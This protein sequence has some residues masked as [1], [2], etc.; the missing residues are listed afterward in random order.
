MQAARS[1]LPSRA[2]LS[3]MIRSLQIRNYALIESL[4]IRFSEGLT[5]ITGETGAGKSILLGALGMIMGERADTKALYNDAEKC[6]VE[7]VFDIS[8]YNLRPF[9]DANELDF[10]SELVI[11]REIL[12]S[13][14]SRAFVNDSPVNL[15][16]LEDLSDSLIDLHQQFDSLDINQVSFQLRMI[17]ALAGNKDL[18]EKYQ[19][20]F[21][22]YQS[23][24]RKLAALEA[25][26]SQ[27]AREIEFLQFQLDELEAANLAAGEQETLES[28][29]AK[30]NNAE[31]I[32]RVTGEAFQGLS[33]S[34]MAVLSQ[35]TDMRNALQS[36]EKVSPEIGQLNERLS[37]MIVELQDLSGEFEKIAEETEYDPGRIQEVEQRLD[38]IYRLQNKYGVQTTPELLALK[39]ETEQR[40]HTFADLSDQIVE[41]KEQIQAEKN[42]LQKL[43]AELRAKRQSVGPAF[44]E[45]VEKRLGQLSM[46]HAQLK[47]HF[48]ELQEF[49]ATGL[50]EVQFRF[51]ANKGG[52]LQ[53]IKDVASGGE[54]SRL[55]LAAKS[56]IAG[57]ISFPTLIFDEIDS[58]VSGDVALSVG[59]LLKALS[60]KHQVVS[61][62]HSPQI[63]AK[64]DA[65]YFIYK[66]DREDRTVTHVRLLNPDERI[67]AIATMLSQSPPSDSAIENARELMAG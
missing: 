13:G 49:T 5:I 28:E 8:Q 34:D 57:A 59:K 14:K 54:L 51:A 16:I 11:R 37:G 2:P 3:A 43:A 18:L 19:G 33:E 4:E 12:P 36:L 9:F 44:G 56:L 41:L 63:A 15:K 30:L 61:I 40:L 45:E 21:R 22:K 52:K 53:A 26:N 23:D 17:D 42:I 66:K 58:G 31:D 7:G 48:Q 10:D 46:K 39:E 32:K 67:R 6:V 50:D 1:A 55:N 29:I 24:T 25:Q 62:T 20:H 65:H 27:A 64:A 38:L 35:L 60:L 47:V